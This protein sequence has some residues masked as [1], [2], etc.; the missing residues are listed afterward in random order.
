MWAAGGAL[1]GGAAGFAVMY[2]GPRGVGPLLLI[3]EVFA[4][5]TGVIGAGIGAVAEAIVHA[6][7]KRR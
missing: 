6:R 2:L 4:V 1:I 3:S 7:P 5:F